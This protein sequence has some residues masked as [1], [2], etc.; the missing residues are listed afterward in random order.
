MVGYRSL[1]QQSMGTRTCDKE[2]RGTAN[3]HL[4]RRSPNPLY[5]HRALPDGSAVPVTPPGL[6]SHPRADESLG[7]L[8]NDDEDCRDEY[9]F[10]WDIDKSA[11]LSSHLVPGA[12][13]CPSFTVPRTMTNLGDTTQDPLCD[14]KV[15]VRR[16]DRLQVL[17]WKRGPERGDDPGKVAKPH[18]RT[19]ARILPPRGQLVSPT[20]LAY[21]AGS[22]WLWRNTVPSS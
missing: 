21:A 12:V 16:S 18:M 19:L 3:I 22:A 15:K 6:R 13:P 8:R 20:I 11:V 10:H 4:Q 7:S 9:R 17:S 5:L 2:I 14:S 1:V